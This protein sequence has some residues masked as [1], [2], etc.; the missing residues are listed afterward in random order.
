MRVV[1]E[2]ETS[3]PDD[4]LTLLWLAD[5]PAVE[6]LGVVI[7]PGTVEQ[8]RLVRW[9]LDRTAR[10]RTPIGSYIG[11]SAWAE[12]DPR[13]SGVSSFHRRAFGA[14][15][16]DHPTGVV[17]DGVALMT[18]LLAIDDVTALVGAPP[19]CLGR[20]FA[21]FAESRLAQWVQQ[22]GFAGVNLVKDP[23]PKFAGRTTCASFNPGGAPS[24]T[25]ALLA[26]RRIE[27]RVFVS[28]NVCHGIVFDVAM[29]RSLDRRLAA[30]AAP[31]RPGLA[32]MLSG[33]EAYLV[34]RPSGKALHD[35]L[36]AACAVEERVCSLREV[37]I[38][39][40]RG[41]WGARSAVDTGT[42]ITV[43]VDRERLLDVLST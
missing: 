43:D 21:T 22:G 1:L 10:V 36:A 40:E 32:L 11:P 30:R 34:E 42:W 35:L 38:F 28:K 13:R 4:F 41:E 27:R 25:L 16:V 19:R 33:L 23:L 3:D 2:M 12:R 8:C 9:A 18:E 17:H 7:S 26:D 39:R 14:E 5:H 31:V 24:E 6:L 29:R 37:E 20:A 15:A